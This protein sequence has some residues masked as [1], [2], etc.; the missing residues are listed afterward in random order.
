MVD[1]VSV[2][3]P[4]K[5][6]QVRVS[7]SERLAHT[8]NTTIM[9]ITVS[10]GLELQIQAWMPYTYT[11]HITISVVDTTLVNISVRAGNDGGVGV[12]SD[13]LL[14]NTAQISQWMY[15]A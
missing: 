15:V 12:W 6:Y 4:I 9:N 11:T 5:Y 3:G 8:L 13:P 2:G 10:N 14:I 1:D 7:H